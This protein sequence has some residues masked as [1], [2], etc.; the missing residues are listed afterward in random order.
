MAKRHNFFD[1]ELPTV[2]DMAQAV[3]LVDTVVRERW[4]D[5][6]SW[7][8]VRANDY[9]QNFAVPVSAA[10]PAPN[11]PWNI[12]EFQV[13]FDTN[14]GQISVGAGST[15]A[16]NP[17]IVGGVAYDVNSNRIYIPQDSVYDPSG[18][19][20]LGNAKSS[21]N[22]NLPLPG[23]NTYYLWLEYLETPDSTY[24]DVGKDG[25][26]HYPRILDGYRL[27]LTT[28]VT[29]PN[30][31][32][33]SIFL[34]KI[35][36][37][38]A[39]PGTLT[40]TSGSADQGANGNLI[41]AVPATVAG[42]PNR[43][44]SLVRDK[45][46]EVLLNIANDKPLTYADN[47]RHTLHDHVNATGSVA[48]TPNNPHG[49]G[50]DDIPGG[51]AEPKA[52]TALSETLAQGIVDL[53]LNNNSP[54]SASSA[55]ALSIQQSTL[56]PVNLLVNDI[57][58]SGINSA[59]QANWIR[60]GKFSSGQS[61]YVQGKRMVFLYPTL[62]SSDH[63][64]DA[65]I[66]PSVAG[67]GDAYVGFSNQAGFQDPTGTYLIFG[68]YAVVGGVDVLLVRKTQFL[69]YPTD[70][71]VDPSIPS[72]HNRIDLGRVYWNGS[73]IF[74]D[75][76]MDEQINPVPLRSIGLV[77]PGQLSTELKSDPNTGAI[78]RK[79]VDNLV[80][81]SQFQFGKVASQFPSWTIY[82]AAGTGFLP[83]ANITQVNSGSLASLVTGGPGAL[84]GVKFQVI[85]AQTTGDTRFYSTLDRV[86]RPN[87]YY[88]ISFEYNADPGWNT[89]VRVGVNGDN[90]G[91]STSQITTGSPAGS[92]MDWN[93]I[94]DGTWHRGSLIVQTIPT[95]SP[96][97]T[98]YLELRLD[99]S[100]SGS[101]ATNLYITNV[102][103][104]EGEW[105]SGFSVNRGIPS[106]ATILWDMNSTCPPGFTENTSARQKFIVGADGT[107]VAVGASGGTDF[108]PAS[109]SLST[110]PGTAHHHTIPTVDENVTF[111]GS[112][113]ITVFDTTGVSPHSPF[114][115]SSESSHTHPLDSTLP[116]YGF[117]L[118]RAL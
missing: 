25:V 71:S 12:G 2:E 84:T 92:P 86:L 88:A 61:A 51:T 41:T 47:E 11:N 63:A 65:S 9:P 110:G 39:F 91:G 5:T 37:A 105:V 24:S 42:E 113:Q 93:I 60:V 101:S 77:G 116:Y 74:R 54:A 109:G 83:N 73:N 108:N 48:P 111:T 58:G 3:G 96:A 112:N 46:V 76:L 21:G 33:V 19:D 102:Q 53:N 23:F 78:S 22:I 70:F 75:E 31:D 62:A 55:C 34:A 106:G 104:Q 30:G 107:N 26:I 8:I 115:T 29:A 67:S 27:V 94:A 43:V 38:V 10:N 117:K 49:L 28:T 35:V 97:N 90:T 68:E 16:T 52:T 14:A 69:N 87:A 4:Q 100:V 82:D 40:I 17:A 66:D 13:I 1:R 57:Q 20:P 50:I 44:Y 114:P 45:S 64:S 95:V 103:V 72:A 118:C 81:N 85:G 59:V 56:Q 89:R 7:G 80:G 15:Q 99:A 18:V 32:G 36:W 79:V 6:R 98:N